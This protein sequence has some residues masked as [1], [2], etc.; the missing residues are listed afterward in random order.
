MP[1][2]KRY[3]E[4]SRSRLAKRESKEAFD[5]KHEPVKVDPPKTESIEI[6]AD[7]E[8]HAT[9]ESN[10]KRLKRIKTQE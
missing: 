3:A 5:K 6:N 4:R 9:P 10:K 1:G 8:P 7:T 2:T